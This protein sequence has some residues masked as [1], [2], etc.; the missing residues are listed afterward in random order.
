MTCIRL[1]RGSSSERATDLTSRIQALEDV[2]L[3]V[4]GPDDSKSSEGSCSWTAGSVGT[5][6]EWIGQALLD[7][8]S[9]HVMWVR[10]GYG[11][12]DCLPHLPWDLLRSSGDRKLVVGFSD[13]SAVQLALWTLLKWPSIHGPMIGGDAWDLGRRD[14]QRLLAWL[15]SGGIEDGSIPV[16]QV[17]EVGHS[18]RRSQKS[19]LHGTL[20]G[21]CLSV[22]T[23]LIGTPFVPETFAGHILFFE[24]IGEN[25]GRVLRAL[26][27]WHQS[28]RLTG[29]VALVLGQ[30]LRVDGQQ[31]IA[32][33][34]ELNREIAQRYGL[35]V[36]VT[37][38]FGHG[39]S[40]MPLPLGVTG[41][42]QG[43][44]LVWRGHLGAGA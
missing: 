26:N 11:A 29:V 22:I 31:E 9:S 21:G 37:D 42:I 24:D 33:R 6:S 3:R 30:F 28:G 16:S 20:L 34:E 2:G 35:P 13:V 7:A 25:A 38:A 5:R 1:V 15:H 27:Q 36:F 18:Q 10:G 19:G 40:N 23:N 14:V 39:V 8:S 43:G 41:M 12:S 32:H 4:V 17:V 44:Q